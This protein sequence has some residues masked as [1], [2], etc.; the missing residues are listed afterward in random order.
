MDDGQFDSELY[1]F[2]QLSQI[3]PLPVELPEPH[4]LEYRD[5]PGAESFFCFAD[6]MFRGNLFFMQL[7]TRRVVETPIISLRTTYVPCRTFTEFIE[8][9]L[10]DA[11]WPLV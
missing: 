10:K 5:F 9:Y 7:T 11:T 4:Y 3:R 2:W 8:K 1:C 6:W